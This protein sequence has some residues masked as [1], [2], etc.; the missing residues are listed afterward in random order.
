MTEYEDV[1]S[2]FTIAW[3]K[4]WDGYP[5]SASLCFGTKV[6]KLKKIFSV[7]HMGPQDPSDERLMKGALADCLEEVVKRMR[8]ER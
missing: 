8:E 3:D 6:E 4:A 1:C 5:V 2:G 7:D